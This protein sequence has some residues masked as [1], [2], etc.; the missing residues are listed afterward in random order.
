MV[1]KGLLTRADQCLPAFQSARSIKLGAEC[2]S[3]LG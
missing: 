3:G 1:G 2:V